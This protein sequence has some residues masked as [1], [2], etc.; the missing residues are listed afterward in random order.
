MEK[1]RSSVA[2]KVLC[3]IDVNRRL[4]MYKY[5]CVYNL[6]GEHTHAKAPPSGSYS[7]PQVKRLIRILYAIIKVVRVGCQKGTR[8]LAYL[9]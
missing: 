9:L 8:V 7:H 1:T 2:A 3:R 6:L 4:L 5:M